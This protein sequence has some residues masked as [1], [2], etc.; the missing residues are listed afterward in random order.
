MK[1]STQNKME[2]A[3]KDTK[4]KVKETTGRMINNRDLEA[5]GRADQ[6][7]GKVQK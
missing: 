3:A 1:D 7:K 6:A 5:S 2:G 4:G